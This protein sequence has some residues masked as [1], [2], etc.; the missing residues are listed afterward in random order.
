[1]VLLQ[2]TRVPRNLQLEMEHYGF[3]N[4]ILFNSQVIVT[5]SK[6]YTCRDVPGLIIIYVI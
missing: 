3:N 5:P 2:F 4:F 6:V 1:M